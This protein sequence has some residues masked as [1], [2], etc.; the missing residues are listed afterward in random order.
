MSINISNDFHQFNTFPGPVDLRFGP[1]MDQIRLKIAIWHKN[2]RP[3][4][5]DYDL[6]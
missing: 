5:N 2:V 4:V 3:K 1:E 6:D